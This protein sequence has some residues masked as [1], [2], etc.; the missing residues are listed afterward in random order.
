MLYKIRNIKRVERE[1]EQFFIT[2][3]GI[4]TQEINY[5]RPVYT[6]GQNISRELKKVA[7]GERKVRIQERKEVT[8]E[9]AKRIV[10]ELREKDMIAFHV[11]T[12]FNEDDIPDKRFWRTDTKEI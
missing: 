7:K 11:F 9:I 12:K 10:E 4:V 8:K 5:V 6:T 3:D 1:G 2:Y